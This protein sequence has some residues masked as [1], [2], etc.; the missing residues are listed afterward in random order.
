MLPW[1]AIVCCALV[2]DASVLDQLSDHE[3][4]AAA[5]LATTAGGGLGVIPAMEGRT[6]AGER[7]RLPVDLASPTGGSGTGCTAILIV[8]FGR[9]ASNAAR[10]WGQRLAADAA[11]SPGTVYFEM[12]VLAS[13][14]RVLRGAVVRLIESS[15]S[16][17]ARHH[18][19][20]ITEEEAAWRKAVDFHDAA[21]PYILVVD[22]H[23]A[24]RWRTSGPLSAPLY[25][26]LREHLPPLS[27]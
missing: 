4:H 21:V 2:L 24:V 15:L 17:R 26:E 14:P 11:N 10:D 19:L 20:P 25:A 27:H 6:L 8:G 18:F 3:V 22:D 7:V 23:G 12:P 1:V 13:V 16:E 9:E 5:A